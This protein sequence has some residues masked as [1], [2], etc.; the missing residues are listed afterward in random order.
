MKHISI[1][2]TLLETKFRLDPYK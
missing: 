1:D 2:S